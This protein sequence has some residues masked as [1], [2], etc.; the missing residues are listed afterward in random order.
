MEPV[1]TKKVL[2]VVVGVVVVVVVGVVTGK[3]GF[4]EEEEDAT[5]WNCPKLG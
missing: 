5:G 1:E 4:S 3:A 2:V